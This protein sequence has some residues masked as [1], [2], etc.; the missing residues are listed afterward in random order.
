[1][2]N[3]STYVALLR[4]IN[5]GGKNLLPMK[6]LAFIFVAADCANVR[7]YITSGNV[8]FTA[9]A[10][11]PNGFPVLITERIRARFGYRVPIIIR[12][13]EQLA[14]TIRDNPFLK[15]G[16]PEKTLHVFFLADLPNAHAVGKLDPHRSPPD[17][18]HVGEQEIYLHLPNGVAR[19]K[20]SNAYFDAKLSTTCTGRNWATVRKLFEMMHA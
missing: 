8:I 11:L 3:T 6:E 12:S 5:V 14:R 13:P 4:G 15:A 19:S 17:A 18:F 7:T 9:P 1:M 10:P 2:R 20:L 16:E